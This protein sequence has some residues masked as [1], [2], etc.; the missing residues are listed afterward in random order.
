[1]QRLSL[2]VA[3]TPRTLPCTPKS[4]I[5]NRLPVHAMSGTDLAHGEDDIMT[6]RTCYAMSG[7]DI[8]Y[9]ATRVSVGFGRC[10][11]L[12]AYELAM[13]CPVLTSRMVLSA[14]GWACDLQC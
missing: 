6:I 9:G 8:A 4:N 3:A 10:A 2:Y 1:M 14:Y 11:P 12:P 13:Q 5:R 7:T